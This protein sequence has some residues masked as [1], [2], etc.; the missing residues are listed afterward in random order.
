MGMAGIGVTLRYEV[1]RGNRLPLGD[2]E[3]VG[4]DG[5]AFV[6]LHCR[7]I[8]ASRVRKRKINCAK[9][10]GG[11]PKK[12]APHWMI[13]W[14][15]I[16]T[17]IAKVVLPILGLLLLAAAS[18]DNGSS[19]APTPR[20]TVV[21]MDAKAWSI[22][23]SPGMPPHPTPQPGGG[24]YFDFPTD[25]NSVHY[26]LAAVNMAAS[27]YVD[28]SIVVTT[29]GTP[30]FVYNLEPHNTCVYPAH[31]RFLLQE[32]GDDLSGRNGKQYFRW[33][34]NSVAYPLA[35]GAANLR[36]SL[37]DLSQWTSV[38]GEKANASAAATAGFQQAI[39]NLGSVGFSFGGGCS[40]G[41]GVRVSGGGARFAVTSYA[42]K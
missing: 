31:V 12:K 32:K 37:T 24:W 15:H 5:T 42:V 8:A 29:S 39:A 18:N 33:W 30:V 7:A 23:Y 34:S 19:P 41:H 1:L 11:S 40:Y 14:I 3:S 16:R 22:L 6:W 38:F 17:G 28:A 25:P 9:H 2:Q 10:S 4:R 21:P 27:S 13:D 26:V 35:S 36:A 20:S